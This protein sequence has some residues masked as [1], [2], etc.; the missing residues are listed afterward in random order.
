MDAGAKQMG[1]KKNP[2]RLSNRK[3][4]KM[5]LK[6]KRDLKHKNNYTMRF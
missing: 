2:K 6:H 1:L 5:N 3:E 4:T